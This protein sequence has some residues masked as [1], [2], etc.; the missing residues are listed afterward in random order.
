MLNGCHGSSVEFSRPG[1]CTSETTSARSRTGSQLQHEY[2]SIF[3]IV[4]YHAITQPYEPE[5][6]R[7]RRRDDGGLAPRRRARSER[8]LALRAVAGSGT[9]RAGVD[10][11]HDHAARRARATDAVQGKVAAA[12]ERRRPGSS[13]IRCFRRPTFCSIAPTWCRSAKTRSST[14]SCRASSRAGGTRRS[15]TDRA[16][17]GGRRGRAR[18]ILPRAQAA[19]H[20][21]AAH[22]GTRRPVEDVEVDGQHHRRCSS[23]RSRSGRSCGPAVTDPKRIKQHGPGDARGVQH[24]PPAQGVQPASRPSSTSRRNAR[25]RGGAASTA[26]RCWPSRWRR[27]WCRFARAPR[28]WRRSP[29]CV[30]DALSAGA[31]KCRRL[32]RE[33]MDVVRERMGF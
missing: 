9:Y 18:G 2:E 7:E 14:S 24:L 11:Q 30:D 26:R 19:A 5:Q 16:T 3:C 12:G 1:S 25:R 29:S 10:L 21:D 22:H 28:R 20:A 32:A 6:L 15:A 23:R 13:T 4:D 27:S 31:A 8:V 33:T 17:N